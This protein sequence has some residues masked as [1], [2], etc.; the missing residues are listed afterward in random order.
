MHQHIVDH[1]KLEPDLNKDAR[2][3][4]NI[5]IN[6]MIQLTTRDEVPVPHVPLHVEKFDQVDQLP[7]IGHGCVALQDVILI[8]DPEQ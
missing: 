4:G 2:D 8:G 7:S 3:N 6:S 5:Y 1:H